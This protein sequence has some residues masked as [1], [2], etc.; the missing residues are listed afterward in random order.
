M[1][2]RELLLAITKGISKHKAFKET[3]SKVPTT[4]CKC[5]SKLIPFN[6]DTRRKNQNFF[7]S[8]ECK[9]AFIAAI[10]P[11][12]PKIYQEAARNIISLYYK[13]LPGEAVHHKDRDHTNNLVSN[14]CVFRTH[15]DHMKYHWGEQVIPVWDGS[16]LIDA[17]ST[18]ADY[19]I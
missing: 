7:C 4:K 6:N 12:Y 2:E 14:L 19:S 3:L 8:P 15:S 1:A 9:D 18:S 10:D 13:L 16:K 17:T 11:P 5:C